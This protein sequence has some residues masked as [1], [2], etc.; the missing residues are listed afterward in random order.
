[1]PDWIVPS[2]LGAESAHYDL[3]RLNPSAKLPVSG[4]LDDGMEARRRI[5]NG[6]DIV[7]HKPFRLDER[8]A[9]ANC[10]WR[11]YEPT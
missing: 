11:S 1:M 8:R 4:G 9:P 3:K 10:C 7:L 6:C 5:G 2:R